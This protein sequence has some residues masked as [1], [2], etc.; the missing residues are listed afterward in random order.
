VSLTPATA[1]K[2]FLETQSSTVG[3][4]VTVDVRR[5]RQDGALPAI[6]IHGPYA[7]PDDRTAALSQKRS[8]PTY[9]VDVWQREYGPADQYGKTP[10]LEDP[11]LPDIVAALL[12]GCLINTVVG[13][14]PGARIYRCAVISWPVEL[15]EPDE[16]NLVH[17]AI[18]IQ[19]HRNAIT[20]R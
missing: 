15:S 3:A 19:F 7:N 16:A 20:H 10:R 18:D 1:V 6:V 17:H 12:D 9:Q 11:L 4:K 13:P 2:A 5:R 8:I 14:A